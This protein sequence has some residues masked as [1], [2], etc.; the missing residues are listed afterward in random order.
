[1]GQVV[2]VD[3]SW[4]ISESVSV[5]RYNMKCDVFGIKE[6]LY[7]MITSTKYLELAYFCEQF[8]L[9]ENCNN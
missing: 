6:M 2:T 7:Y 8:N 4:E 3:G 1:M 5:S 9:S